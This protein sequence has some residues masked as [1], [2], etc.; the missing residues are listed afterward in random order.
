MK[1][2]FLALIFV[3]STVVAGAKQTIVS[4]ASE[5]NNGTWSA[6]DTILM[7]NGTWTNQSILL[8]GIGT[9]TQPIVLLAETPGSVILTGT[10]KI[11]FSGKFVVVSGLFFK[12]G[13][14]SG[15]DVIS[16]RTSSSE[17]AEN[18][19]LTNSA[20]VNYNPSLNT[21]DSKWVS[22]YG[23][24]NKVD[25][26]SFENKNN[27][28]TLMVVWLVNGVTVNHIIAQNYF[29]YRNS[30]L[31]ANG[32]ELNGQEIIRVGDSGTSM[33]TA[34]VTVQGNFFEHC[35]GE[36]EII[37]NKSCGNYYSN[38]VF[39]ECHG[40]LTLR[41]GNGCTVDGNYFFG[42]GIS[43]SGGVRVIGESHKVY[44]NYFEKLR[45]TD[46][47]SAIC[48][49]RGKLNSLASEYFQVKNA[50]IAF[51]TMVDCTESF[52]I[53]YNSS[54]TCTMPPIGTVIAHNHVY[55][56]TASNI[57]V[58]V[59]LTDAAMD[60][61]WKNNLFN[62]GKYTNFTYTATQV[63]TGKDPKMSLAGTSINMYEPAAGSALLNYPTVEYPEVI[64]DIRGR[65]RG[66]TAKIPGASQL[67]GTITRIMPSKTGVGATFFNQTGTDVKSQ[68]MTKIFHAFISGN[69]LKTS[70]S[71]SGKLNIFD[72]T[73]KCLYQQLLASGTSSTTLT[74][75]GIY[76]LCFNTSIGEHYTQKIIVD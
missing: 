40:M 71:T 74:Q 26:C 72:L 73:G 66:T 36:I 69:N 54:S 16:F 43:E 41:H 14:L 19:T 27:S 21:V 11:G 31:D 49:V 57:N 30:N 33:T 75:K 13:T 76:V 50:L 42:N 56:A 17:L 15:S 10:S 60:I 2:T 6:G 37:S 9:E 29:G 12:N 55:N 59:D 58:D 53:N 38:N 70:V 1:N 39:F 28:G 23:K 18:C 24:N 47:R 25:H 5:I 51:N 34:S 7:K 64:T 68:S 62:T 63:I 46:Y 3:F 61:T 8:K 52:S 20:I 32:T 45:G 65:E 44:N 35:N 67:S 4:T 48:V 22:I